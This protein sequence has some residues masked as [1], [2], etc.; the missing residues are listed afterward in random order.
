MKLFL[1]GCTVQ[2]EEGGPVGLVIDLSG[3]PGWTALVAWFGMTGFAVFE[4]VF[5]DHLVPLEIL[6]A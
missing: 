3:P 6:P 4:W 2:R 1:V 5:L